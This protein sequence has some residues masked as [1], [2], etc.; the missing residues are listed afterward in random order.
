MAR[1]VCHLEYQSRREAPSPPNYPCHLP[2]FFLESLECRRRESAPPG[3]TRRLR[4]APA[5]LPP[6]S[7][8][9]PAPPGYLRR[10]APGAVQRV[11][12]APL[13]RRAS[14]PPPGPPGR[15]AVSCAWGWGLRGRG[16]HL[17]G[18]EGC[19][20]KLEGWGANHSGCTPPAGLWPGCRLSE[21]PTF[22]HCVLTTPGGGNIIISTFQERRL[23]W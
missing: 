11:P 2:G 17:P 5:A 3:P 22:F 4:K 19:F 12:R 7:C 18:A 15:Q 8:P 16:R 21:V 20:G 6:A 14:L 23:R 13:R 1:R 9:R 10:P